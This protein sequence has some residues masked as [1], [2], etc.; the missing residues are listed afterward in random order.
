MATLMRRLTIS[1]IM[2]LSL[3]LPA[4]GH[5]DSLFVVCDTTAAHYSACE[6]AVQGDSIATDTL[7]YTKQLQDTIAKLNQR[8]EQYEKRI[9]RR[10]K[11][12]M[13]LLPSFYR[14]QY[15]GST[16]L[17]NLGVGWEYGKRRQWE[18]D[19]M[20]GYVPKYDKDH[21]LATFTLRQTY[22]P[23]TKGLYRSRDHGSDKLWFTWQPLSCGL[24]LNS[25]LD[26]DYWTKEPERYPDRDY[27]RFSTKIRFH[28]FVGQRYT[29]HIPRNKRYLAKSLSF[30]WELSTCDL[31]LVSK[32]NNASI[33]LK[34]ILSLSFGLKMRI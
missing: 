4:L 1:L 18:T 32:W 22:V 8:L 6:N 26:G 17:L 16:S 24:Y 15:A 33:P 23:W 34:D 31:Y 3:T 2:I 28:I 19:F 9:E 7:L 21:A 30:I 14:F 25:V 27:Y 20:F 13:S 5:T 10:K 29:L 11:V 12:W